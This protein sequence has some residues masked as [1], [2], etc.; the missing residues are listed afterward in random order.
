MCGGRSPPVRPLA[1]LGGLHHRIMSSLGACSNHASG[2]ASGLRPCAELPVCAEPEVGSPGTGAR[3]RG[4]EAAVRLSESW[5]T[6]PSM[7][8]ALQLE[9]SRFKRRCS[10]FSSTW[11]GCRYRTSQAVLRNPG[12]ARA[13]IGDSRR[14]FLGLQALPP[15]LQQS[16]HLNCNREDW[17]R[18][19]ASRLETLHSPGRWGMLSELIPD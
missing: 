13:R 5:S 15:E 11:P 6:T 2:N 7:T 8:L 14:L 12:N 4:S 17:V 9:T 18:A 16:C 10:S 3:P 19:D 1:P